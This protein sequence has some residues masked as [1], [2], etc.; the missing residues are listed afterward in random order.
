[1]GFFFFSTWDLR[2]L[3]ILIFEFNKR[4]QKKKKKK[5][6]EKNLGISVFL[7]PKNK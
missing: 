7:E 5:K 4:Y 6:C 2:Q 1:M 3:P